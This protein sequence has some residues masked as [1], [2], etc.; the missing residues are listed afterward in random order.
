MFI[1]LAAVFV[2]TSV[3]SA[4]ADATKQRVQFDMK[5]HPGSTFVLGR[6]AQAR[7]G[8]ARLQRGPGSRPWRRAA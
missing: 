1:A 5:I 3:A 4:G 6:S 7:L 8:D 2:L